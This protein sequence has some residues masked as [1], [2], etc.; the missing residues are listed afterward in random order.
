M[1]SFPLNLITAIAPKPGAV[2]KATIVSFHVLKFSRIE[3]R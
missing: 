1:A 3:Q 2:A